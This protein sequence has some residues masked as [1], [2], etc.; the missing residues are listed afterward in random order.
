MN[1]KKLIIFTDI[2]DT[3]IDESTE[4]LAPG[5]ELVLHADCFPGAKETMLRLYEAGF[6]IV[7]VADGLVQSFANSMKQNGL[8]SIFSAKIIS[9]SCGERKPHPKMFQDAMDAIG[10]KS[11][12]KHRIIMVGNNLK[13]DIIG[14]N[15]FGIRSVLLTWSPRY[16]YEPTEEDMVPDETIKKPEELWDLA[17]KLETELEAEC[18]GNKQ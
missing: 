13:R 10:L 8:D 2:G 17:I 7:M 11:K 4:V 18:A 3:I 5:S 12:D 15:R 1:R 14:A 16:N 6:T 9:E